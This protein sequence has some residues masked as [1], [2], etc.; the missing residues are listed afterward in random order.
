MMSKVQVYFSDSRA[1]SD[2]DTFRTWIRKL[3]EATRID[4]TISKGD[5]VAIKTHFGTTGNDRHVKPEH[6]REIVEKV[7]EVGGQ[8]FV[9]DTTGIGLLGERG[10][11]ASLLTS[12]ARRRFTEETLGAPVIVADAPKGLSGDQNRS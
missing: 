6:L 7:R 10:T 3:F 4:E 2:E 1:K 8:P 11:A 12:S 5:L 9:T